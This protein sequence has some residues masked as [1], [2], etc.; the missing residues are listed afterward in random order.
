[1]KKYEWKVGT[2][3]ILAILAL[4]GVLFFLSKQAEG[5][6]P[7]PTPTVT[8]SP[9][10]T[11]CHGACNFPYKV[12]LPFLGQPRYWVMDYIEIGTSDSEVVHPVEWHN[13]RSF[14]NI[15]LGQ[16]LWLRYIRRSEGVWF[17]YRW[18]YDPE[19]VY[20]FPGGPDWDLGYDPYVS[21]QVLRGADFSPWRIAPG[22]V[23]VRSSLYN[24][25]NGV[26]ADFGLMAIRIYPDGQVEYKLRP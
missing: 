3:A 5:A 7:E 14:Y 13:L 26:I 6:G 11:G 4:L 16:F 22:W 20:N 21:E 10:P 8:P 19:V 1:M 2:L 9:T 24:P 18:V 15:P 23:S 25:L 12:Y 17:R